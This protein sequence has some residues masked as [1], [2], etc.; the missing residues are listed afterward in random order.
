MP[1]S[2]AKTT[3][4]RGAL[5]ILL[6]LLLFA[7]GAALA[8]AQAVDLE[9]PLPNTASVP[10]GIAAGPNNTI[11]F[12]EFSSNKIGRIDLAQLTGC[13][14]NPGQCLTEW[15]VPN[16]G[17]GPIAIAAGSD[18][19]MWFTENGSKRIG[20]ITPAGIASDFAAT[21]SPSFITAG[22]SSDPSSLWYTEGNSNEGAR[23][24]RITTSAPQTATEYST[25]LPTSGLGAIAVG[26]DGNIWFTEQKYPENVRRIARLNVANRTGCESNPSQ[27]ITEFE[28]PG[29]ITVICGLSSGSDG[30]VWFTLNGGV[31]RLTPAGVLST[32]SAS[33]SDQAWITAG[34]ASDGALWAAGEST[35]NGI[36]RIRTDGTVSNSIP[37]PTSAGY[38][39]GI[40]LGPDGNIWFT[41]RYGS[42]VGRVN[43]S[44]GPPGPTPTP[45]PIPT[46]QPHLPRGRVTP[47]AAPTPFTH[48]PGR[49]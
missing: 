32:F 26:P 33:T 23:V 19:N 6:W 27:C 44:A 25:V 21:R 42:K 47:V 46:P 29:A 1:G 39:R 12:V 9:I 7:G 49:P 5:R 17:K 40:A 43:L 3:V 31:G 2:F 8:R 14:A 20:M 38:P 45:T 4:P 22:P 11:W 28:V 15:D 30:N 41:E 37:L 24:V 13:A 36:L 34:P 35:F 48:I 16:S 18:G 10:W